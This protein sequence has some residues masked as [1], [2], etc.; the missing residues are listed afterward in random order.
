MCYIQEFRS[1]YRKVGE[2]RGHAFFL[3]RLK[4]IQ[5]TYIKEY[6]FMKNGYIV[7]TIFQ[8]ESERLKCLTN[9]ETADVKNK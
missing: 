8:Q 2:E 3:K 1:R 4:I 9:L 6:T 7:I 5:N